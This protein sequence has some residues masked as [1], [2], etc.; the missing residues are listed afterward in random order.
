MSLLEEAEKD[1]VTTKVKNRYETAL[2]CPP[3][4]PDN[5]L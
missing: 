5:G 3:P 1:K 2:N 4:P